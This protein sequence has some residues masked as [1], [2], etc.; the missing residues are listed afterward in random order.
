MGKSI[1]KLIYSDEKAKRA[2]RAKK[3]REIC[4]YTNHIKV[5]GY[6]YI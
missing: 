2:K 4:E 3:V 5:H 6:I 1:Y